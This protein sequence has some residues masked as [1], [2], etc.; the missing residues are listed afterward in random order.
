MLRTSLDIPDPSEWR[1]EVGYRP[2]LVPALA[3]AYWH[4]AHATENRDAYFNAYCVIVPQRNL[5]MSI[6]QRMRVE[7]VLAQAYAGE[8]ALTQALTSLIDA[9]DMASLMQDASAS[10]LLSF[11]AGAICHWHTQFIEARARYETALRT[12]RSLE[13]DTGPLDSELEIE[14]LTRIAGLDCELAE[15]DAA[16]AHVSEAY[17]LIA[18]WCPATP[19]A[20]AQR[21]VLAWVNA[22]LLHW[23]GHPDL[24]LPLAIAAADGLAQ[25]EVTSSFARIGGTV[26]D[27]ALDFAETFS[28]MESPLLRESIVRRAHAY[29]QRALDASRASTDDVGAGI[30]RLALIRCQRLLGRGPH[31]LDEIARIERRAQHLGDIGLRGRAQVALGDELRIVGNAEAARERYYVA[32]SLFEEH[33]F[34]VLRTWPQRYIDASTPW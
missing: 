16:E 18:V 22:V 10:I 14:L 23:R 19:K 24:A 1:H 27:I 20:P 29:A 25:E 11:L 30:A 2:Q 7:Y 28:S 31:R 4:L 5:P 17:T 21:A 32:R 12:L 6:R 15:L 26:A 9:Q 8:Q 34:R 13:A 3:T 33:D